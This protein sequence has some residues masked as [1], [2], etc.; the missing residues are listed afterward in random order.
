MSKNKYNKKS[1]PLNRINYYEATGSASAKP[2]EA[3]AII[4]ASVEAV[5]SNIVKGTGSRGSMNK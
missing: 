4:D 5:G 3:N 2:S 1:N